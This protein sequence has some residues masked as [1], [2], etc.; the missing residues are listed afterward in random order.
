[1]DPYATTDDEG[2]TVQIEYE[3]TDAGP[4]LFVRKPGQRHVLHRWDIDRG[5][6]LRTMADELLADLGA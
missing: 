6:D 4:V 2:G 5:L 1:V 3:I